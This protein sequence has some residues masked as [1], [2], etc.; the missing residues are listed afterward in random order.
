M[1][2]F[3]R[4]VVGEGRAKVGRQRDDERRNVRKEKRDIGCDGMIG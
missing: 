4:W 3:V 1:V 2:R